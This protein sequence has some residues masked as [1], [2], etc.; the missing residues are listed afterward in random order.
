MQPGVS[1]APCVCYSFYGQFP[2]VMR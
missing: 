2:G 1:G